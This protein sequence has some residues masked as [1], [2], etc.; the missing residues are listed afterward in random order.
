[1]IRDG[2]LALVDELMLECHYSRRGASNRGSTSVCRFAKDGLDP[3][4]PD[5]GWACVWR[6]EC[7]R[8]LDLIRKQCIYAHEWT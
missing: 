5:K 6:D 2:T 4:F 7:L 3:R 1:M 8:L